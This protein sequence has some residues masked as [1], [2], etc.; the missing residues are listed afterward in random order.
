MAQINR[1][2]Q[3]IEKL[4]CKVRGGG[5][6]G[7]GLPPTSVQAGLVLGP[8]L[9]PAAPVSGPGVATEL[10]PFTRPGLAKLLSP[11]PPAPL[12]SADPPLASL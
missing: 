1:L 12:G 6:A 11:K 7:W 3:L 10:R 8:L 4:E 5:Q 2:Q 9:L